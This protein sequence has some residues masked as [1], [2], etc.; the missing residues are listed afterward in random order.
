M[1]REA[2]RKFWGCPELVERVLPFLDS[3]SV[4]SLCQALPAVVH[5]VQGKT[6]WNKLIRRTCNFVVNSTEYVPLDPLEETTVQKHAKVMS[7][8]E[9]LML[10]ADPTEPLLDLLDLIC[11]KH[12][13]QKNSVLT[14]REATTPRRSIL[15]KKDFV[16]VSCPR[17]GTHAVS[18][19]GFMLLEEVESALQSTEQDIQCIELHDLK[20]PFLS[21]L[22]SRISRKSTLGTA[23]QNEMSVD[24]E[25]IYCNSKE[26]VEAIS[27]LTQASHEAIF[28]RSLKV[29]ARIGRDGWA[30]LKQAMTSPMSGQLRPAKIV[31]NNKQ[32]AQARLDDVRTIWACLSDSWTFWLDDGRFETFQKRWDLCKHPAHHASEKL[33]WKLL[34]E[35]LTMTERKWADKYPDGILINNIRGGTYS[36]AK[37]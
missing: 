26:S 9:I 37:N 15:P 34:E 2:E 19:A 36:F 12:P 21:A 25:D 23:C 20:E 31:S 5:V 29:G 16:Q 24:V 1:S 33:G 6:P 17:H 30:A 27:I 3:N 32:M 8:A 4:L 7:L 18:P 28:C 11:E 35:F 14:R 13:F 10:M 22:T